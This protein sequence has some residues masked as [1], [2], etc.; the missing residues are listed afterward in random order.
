MSTIGTI[1]FLKNTQM[2]PD[3]GVTF[4]FVGQDARGF[5]VESFTSVDVPYKMKDYNGPIAVNVST[6]LI[7]AAT[8]AD[9]DYAVAEDY[10]GRKYFYYVTAWKY[11]T[12]AVYA[13]V[14]ILD[15]FMTYH[16]IPN[17]V[18]YLPSLIERQHYD[19]YNYDTQTPALDGPLFHLIHEPIP[20]F[21]RD[22]SRAEIDN[23]Q[24]N[25][26]L[27]KYI[28]AWY[29]LYIRKV[30]GNNVEHI[31]R[32][33][34]FAWQ[35]TYNGT[36]WGV[37]FGLNEDWVEH[38]PYESTNP[39]I[40]SI[41]KLPYTPVFDSFTIREQ[42]QEIVLLK[43]DWVFDVDNDFIRVG[44]YDMPIQPIPISSALAN[45]YP[46]NNS[47][48]YA[49]ATDS[50]N[51]T[52]ETK[53]YTSQFTNTRIEYGASSFYINREDYNYQNFSLLTQVDILKYLD[54]SLS[55]NFKVNYEPNL[56]R[57]THAYVPA[58]NATLPIFS[59][60]YMSYIRTRDANLAIRNA[61]TAISVGLSVATIAGGLLLSATGAGAPVGA[62]AVFSSVVGLSSQLANAGIA[63]AQEKQ[64]LEELK[65]QGRAVISQT[66][67]TYSDEDTRINRFNLV[68]E[69][70]NLPDLKT[71]AL[72]FH[73]T[74]YYSGHYE[75]PD[76]SSRTNFNSIKGDIEF[77]MNDGWQIPYAH[78]IN[79][80]ERYR[81]GLMIIHFD[82]YI[83]PPSWAALDSYSRVIALCN[84]EK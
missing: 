55:F 31:T 9:Y 48:K 22:V 16:S 80:K 15:T 69:Q 51:Y 32:Q 83:T 46:A 57:Y 84:K 56:K 26:T 68:T 74:G 14:L 17:V 12:D 21:P 35:P 2:S 13:C 79:L 78:Y 10:T 44:F 5:W 36:N 19:R 39:N 20:D 65:Q 58:V 34:S 47:L 76:L 43:T 70:I 38:V 45:I 77:K 60:D 29:I 37:L 64:K 71:L 3:N 75:V 62:A 61:S 63:N 59:S 28:K 82:E 25:N 52:K 8:T 42:D 27:E 53:I 54:L 18:T 1:T 72:M 6:A 7:S 30:D 73:I 49:A 33:L 23:V 4:D 41:E 11:L 81:N 67:G 40:L 66:T 24:A 50:Y